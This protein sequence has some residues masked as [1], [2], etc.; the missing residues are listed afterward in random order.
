MIHTS[1]QTVPTPFL[2]AGF[3]TDPPGW[4]LLVLWL[5][6]AYVVFRTIAVGLL[7]TGLVHAYILARL[8]RVKHKKKTIIFTKSLYP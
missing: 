3:L 2:T 7:R 8:H 5:S 4:M 1:W 6:F